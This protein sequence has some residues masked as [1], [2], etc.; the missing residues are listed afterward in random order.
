MIDSESSQ[1]GWRGRKRRETALRVTE[2]ALA[3]FCDKGYEATTLDM[4][5]EASGISRRTFFHYFKSKEDIL[6][7]WQAGLPHAFRAIL[8]A[9][10][11]DQPPLEAV[12]RA[13]TRTLVNF[14]ADKAIVINRIIRSSER[15]RA[16]NLAKYLMLEQ[17]TFE[18]LCDLWPQREDRDSLRVLAITAVGILRFSIDNFAARRGGASVVDLIGKAFEDLQCELAYS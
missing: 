6:A 17:V 2:A 8:L 9:E 16:G 15:L 18:A 7:V 12:H 3:L 10:S 1:A 14:D 11:P 13:L 4:I 5:A